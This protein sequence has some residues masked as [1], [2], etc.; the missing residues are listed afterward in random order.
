MRQQQGVQQCSRHMQ[1]TLGALW[2]KGESGVREERAVPCLSRLWGFV[3]RV[4]CE[5]NI[6]IPGRI[7]VKRQSVC[8]CVPW[9]SAEPLGVE[10]QSYS[11]LIEGEEPKEGLEQSWGSGQDREENES[12]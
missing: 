3:G 4:G 12:V 10:V 6:F 9:S 2:R 5:G 8:I 7:A 11:Q 1:L